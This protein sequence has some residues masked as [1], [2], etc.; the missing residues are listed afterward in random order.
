MFSGGEATL[1]AALPEAMRRVRAM[2]FKVGLHTAGPYP[3]RFYRTNDEG[4]DEV[5]RTQEWEHGKLVK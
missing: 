1:Q 4:E 2:G 5:Y 3:E